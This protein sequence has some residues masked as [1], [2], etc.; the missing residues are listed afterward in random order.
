LTKNQES[1]ADLISLANWEIVIFDPA[2]DQILTT[3]AGGYQPKWSPDGKKILYLK[4]DGLYVYN[5]DTKTETQLIAIREGGKVTGTSMIDLSPNGKYLVWTTAKAGVITVKEIVNW[6]TVALKD[7]GQMKVSGAEF[8]WP[9]FS[10][11]SSY[12]VVQ[13]IDARVGNDQERK[14]PRLEIRAFNAKEVVKSIPLTEF[15][16]DAF[17]TD[18]WVAKIPGQ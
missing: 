3:V 15:N 7:V 17:F 8:F 2:T 16:F 18:D 13:A 9:Q 14:N 10:P 1:Y 4:E 5:L 11:D 6:D 12:Y